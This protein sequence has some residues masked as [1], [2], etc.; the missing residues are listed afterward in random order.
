M[1]GRCFDPRF[2]YRSPTGETTS[3]LAL[4]LMRAVGVTAASFGAAAGYSAQAFT[5]IQ[6]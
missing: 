6:A 3:S 2:H 1:A 4:T 5:A